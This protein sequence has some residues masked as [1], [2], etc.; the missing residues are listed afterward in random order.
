MNSSHLI[1]L[2]LATENAVLPTPVLLQVAL[3]VGWAAVLGAAVFWGAR[4]LR[5]ASRLG[6]SLLVVLWA[7]MPGR[8]SPTHWLG[9]AFQV[10][11]LMTV[12]L[13]L[14][15][16]FSKPRRPSENDA[17]R[18]APSVRSVSLGVALGIVLGWVL[19]LDTLAW[20]PVSVY[21]WGFSPVALAAVGGLAVFFWVWGAGCKPQS[22]VNY[23]SFFVVFGVLALFVLTRLPTGNVWDALL[24]PCLWLGLQLVAIRDG[25]RRW[26]GRPAG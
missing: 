8:L 3:H 13:C 5:P 14:Y 4:R 11:S 10:P 22:K 12:V 24:D 20:L 15:L 26:R 18:Q 25:W 2:F 21:A 23:L 7:L 6:L 17:N 16:V 19:L 9:L 1:P